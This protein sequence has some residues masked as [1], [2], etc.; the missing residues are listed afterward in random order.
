MEYYPVFLKKKNKNNRGVFFSEKMFLVELLREERPD[1]VKIR[2]ANE[3]DP[4]KRFTRHAFIGDL[5]APKD[6]SLETE[7]TMTLRALYVAFRRLLECV[8]LSF[9]FEK[10]FIYVTTRTR[11][12]EGEDEQNWIEVTL[13]F[14]REI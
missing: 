5:Y 2:H 13:V 7:K 12:F 6:L 10:K 1:L 8:N 3:L 4:T 14:Y 11:R 9:P